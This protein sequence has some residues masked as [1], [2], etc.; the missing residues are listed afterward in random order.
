MKFNE[1]LVELRKQMG[2]SQ[3]ELGEKLMTSRQTISKWETGQSYPDF[4]R[5]VLLSDFY[6]LSLDELVKGVDVSDVRD[7]GVTAKQLAGI[8]SNIDCFKSYTQSIM[9]YIVG[10]G[11]FMI[12]SFIIVLILKLVFK[13]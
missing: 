7:K 2:L 9:K 6:D 5:L 8:E 12:G 3:E 1:R 11:W 10:L 13:W 4:E